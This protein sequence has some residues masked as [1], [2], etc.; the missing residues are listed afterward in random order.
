MANKTLPRLL[1][2][3]QN[4]QTVLM[5]PSMPWSSVWQSVGVELIAGIVVD[6]ADRLWRTVAEAGGV[7][8]FQGGVSYRLLDLHAEQGE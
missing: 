8:I 6:D 3:S 2:L 1:T 4:S 7:R 5:G